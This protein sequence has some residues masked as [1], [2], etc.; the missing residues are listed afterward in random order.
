M[1]NTARHDRL[2]K[3]ASQEYRYMDNAS[4]DYIADK[5]GKSRIMAPGPI[6][7]AV[8][9]SPQLDQQ[10]SFAR[11]LMGEERWQEL[12]KEWNA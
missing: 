8:R 11:R 4:M 1:S 9:G 3:A 10:V 6:N 2:L 12:N 7:R 5:L